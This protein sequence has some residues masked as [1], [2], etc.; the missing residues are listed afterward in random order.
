MAAI[1]H[2]SNQFG[3]RKQRSWNNTNKQT[4]TALIKCYIQ[5]ENQKITVIEKP[6]KR[7]A[8]FY[9]CCKQAERLKIEYGSRLKQLIVWNM[10]VL[11]K[12]KWY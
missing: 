2:Y 4:F 3:E 12:S 5:D 11:K 10:D 7:P 1:L 8:T 9:E 6:S